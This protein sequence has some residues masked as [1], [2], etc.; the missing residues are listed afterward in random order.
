MVDERAQARAQIRG[1]K[2][3]AESDLLAR[4]NVIGVDIADK[5]T[6]GKNT[7]QLAI[8]VFVDAKQPMSK[9][10]AADRVPKEIDGIPTDVQEMTV[11]LQG[12]SMELVDEVTPQVDTTAYST[13]HGGISMGPLRSV[14]L[15]PPDVPSAGNYIFAGT[16]GAMVRDRGN[17]ATMALT[18][19]HVACVNNTWSVG[20][21]MVQP[22]LLDGGS[23]GN[24]FGSLSRATLS[25]AVD[26]SVVTV[27]TGKSTTASVQDIGDVAGHTAATVGAAVRKRGRT[28]ELTYGTVVST[29]FTVSINY[30][31]D[32]GSHTLHHQIRIQT[33]TS[34]SARFSDHGDSGS[35]IMDGNRMVV[36]LLF[37][38]SSD[39]QWTFA[40]PI[41][42]VLDE[43]NVDLM[44]A[45]VVT[46][47][48]ISCLN[49]RLVVC[50]IT[51]PAACVLTRTAGC[52]VTR[53]VVCI[54]TRTVTCNITTRA[55]SCPV[56]TRTPTCNVLLTRAGCNIPIPDPGPVENG[57]VDDGHG[58]GATTD[59]PEEYW[60]GYLAALEEVNE[61]DQSD[62]V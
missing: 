36:G 23:S 62:E 18:N 47:P 25:D 1:T 14:Y 6:D 60:A 19:F 27:D 57:Q 16:L 55:A 28:T 61:L 2:Q 12:P 53:T 8:V 22:S 51:R 41:Q 44:V 40:N 26:G 48:I 52:N 4:K 13:L 29:D 34:Q 58:Y 50:N 30:G 56:L 59:L 39:G 7:G 20:D 54:T 32:V 37:A 17:G 9:L 49:T 35:V 42:S 5:E 15:T 31:S 33:D 38:G 11:E 24:Q 43:L 21:R 10:S 3:G 46:R 45:P